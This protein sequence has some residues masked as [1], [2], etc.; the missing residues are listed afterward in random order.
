MLVAAAKVFA[1]RGYEDPTLNEIA[2]A[3]G[4]GLQT[5]YRFFPAKRALYLRVCR[6]LHERQMAYYSD[7]IRSNRAHAEKVYGLALGISYNHAQPHL[8]RLQQWKLL[9][10]ESQLFEET[11]ADYW[12]HHY[13]EY[14]KTVAHMGVNEPE[15][16]VISLIGSIVGMAQY[17]TVMGSMRLVQEILKD[18][19][20]VALFCLGNVFR[21]TEW[22]AIRP[23]VKFKVFDVEWIG[24]VHQSLDL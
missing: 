5:I 19:E 14:I 12:E 23:R 16:H 4:V 10:P 15:R 17:I 22:R 24:R 20:G 9:D 21:D 2:A 11:P 1:A 6:L 3:A 13:D 7:L 18:P 8:I